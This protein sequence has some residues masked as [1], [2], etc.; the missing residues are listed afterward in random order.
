MRYYSAKL[1]RF[2]NQDPIEEAG[3][4]NLYAFCGNDGV[5]RFD[6]LGMDGDPFDNLFRTGNPQSE[7]GSDHPWSTTIW[8]SNS[9]TPPNFGSSTSGTQSPVFSYSIGT[10]DARFR[11]DGEHW[12]S[13]ITGPISSWWDNFMA[14]DA[15]VDPSGKGDIGTYLV[16]QNAAGEWVIAGKT[17]GVTTKYA[18][19]NGITGE[20]GRHAYLGGKHLQTRFGK[21]VTEFTLF[22]N[23]T[24]GALADIW[25]TT[26]DKLGF[27]SAPAKALA[28]VLQAIQASGQS[29][30][31][32]A[33][34]QGG[35]IFSEAMRYAGGDLSANSV[36]FD[37]GANNHWVTNS[38]A[39]DVRVNVHGYYYSSWDAVPNVIGFNGNPVSMV[40]STLAS[41]LLWTNEDLSPHTLASEHKRW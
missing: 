15:S 10:F 25:E 13:D 23:P 31:W 22:N 40:G 20:L 30:E 28:G 18:F 21:G 29:V 14:G 39:A 35:A 16:R 12:N 5:N 37:A 7:A 9:D 4:I 24:H 2:L 6:L 1:G 3:G 41:P 8:G 11:P 17:N 32:I 19:V 27:T 38:I 26:M 36:T 33:H 34:S